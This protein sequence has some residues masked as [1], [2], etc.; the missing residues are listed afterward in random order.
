MKNFLT[1]IED[2]EWT[3]K[4]L[5]SFFNQIMFIVFKRVLSKK[6]FTQLECHI[7]FFRYILIYIYIYICIYIYIYYS[8]IY[9]YICIL[10]HVRTEIKY[11][12]WW[13]WKRETQS[14]NKSVYSFFLQFVIYCSV[15]LHR[16]LAINHTIHQLRK[17][18][19]YIY[20]YFTDI[21]RLMHPTSPNYNWEM[22]SNR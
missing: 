9:L 13:S 2:C 12:S 7:C 17:L 8:Y 4:N 14:C 10:F 22:D 16:A 5:S 1:S 19:M 18:Y 21:Y 6:K 3:W 11:Y 20:L 15:F